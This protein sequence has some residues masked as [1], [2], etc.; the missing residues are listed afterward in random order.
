MTTNDSDNQDSTDHKDP[1]TLRRLYWGEELSLSEMANRFGVSRTT[2]HNYMDKFGVPRRELSEANRGNSRVEYAYHTISA[3]GYERWEDYISD[4][5]V[6]VHQLLAISEGR[7][8]SEVFSGDYAVHHKNGVPWDN[9][10]K[11]LELMDMKDHSSHHNSGSDNGMSKLT[12]EEVEEIKRM[13]SEG[14][15]NLKIADEF[16][17]SD[18]TVSNINT[19]KTWTEVRPSDSV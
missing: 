10:P 11:N 9:R 16:D 5:M 4:E 1:E 17:I 7:K 14:V 6:K 8:A 13:L 19:G 2:V 3:N 18:G 12:R 15:S